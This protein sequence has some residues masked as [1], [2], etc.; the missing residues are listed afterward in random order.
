[1]SGPPLILTKV[2]EE[3]WPALLLCASTYEYESAGCEW[4]WV[5]W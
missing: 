5:A 4:E 1:M 2:I 3:E